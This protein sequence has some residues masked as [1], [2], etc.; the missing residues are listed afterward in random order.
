M[1]LPDDV[2]DP[3]DWEHVDRAVVM[4]G[5]YLI[6][7]AIN[8]GSLLK[9][10]SFTLESVRGIQKRIEYMMGEMRKHAQNRT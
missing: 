3:E 9:S 8:D 5:F 1:L 4:F 2:Y 6:Q 10:G 7:E